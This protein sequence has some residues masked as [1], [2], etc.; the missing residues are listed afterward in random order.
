MER[1]EK[2]N[3]KEAVDPYGILACIFFCCCRLS[4]TATAIVC[5]MPACLPLR[6][7]TA[8]MTPH[9]SKVQGPR[10]T[11]GMMVWPPLSL[12]DEDVLALLVGVHWGVGVR[13]GG[14][15]VWV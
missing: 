4:A 7:T 3:Q 10:S 9:R 15:A 8:W 14:A 6:A 11:R 13:G 2:H 12:P 5:K 1:L